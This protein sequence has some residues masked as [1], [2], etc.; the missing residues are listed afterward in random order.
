M[1]AAYKRQA[2]LLESLVYLY[3]FQ[4]NDVLQIEAK[5][6]ELAR[7]QQ[8]I[9]DGSK[10]VRVYVSGP[11]TKGSRTTNF[12]Q[13]ATAQKRLME[14]G[15]YAVLNPMLTMLHPDEPNISWERWLDTDLA[16]I[17]VADLVIRLPGASAGGDK[18]VAYAESIGVQVAY[19]Y[20]IPELRDLF[21]VHFTHETV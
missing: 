18:E 3:R 15:K 7:V 17:E 20:Q 16:W 2:E 5:K 11:I 12:A 21:P 19:A 9:K 14:S 10:L 6:A 4:A 13:A 8:Q 1:I